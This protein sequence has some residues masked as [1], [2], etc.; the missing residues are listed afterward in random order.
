MELFIEVYG[1][2]TEHDEFAAKDV[3]ASYKSF[4]MDYRR[5][6]LEDGIQSQYN[7][8]LSPHR[9]IVIWDHEEVCGSDQGRGEEEAEGI[10]DIHR[11]TPRY[12][13]G[14]PHYS[15]YRCACQYDS[16]ERGLTIDF[17]SP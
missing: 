4:L 7:P 12:L 17:V 9:E 14:L 13:D 1:R 3:K 11:G 8:E 16:D 6:Y 15:P 5:D 2:Y 10:Y